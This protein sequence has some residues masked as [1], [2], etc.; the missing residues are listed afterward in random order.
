MSTWAKVYQSMGGSFEP[1]LQTIMPLVF[2]SATIRAD[3]SVIGEIAFARR[4]GGLLG[5]RCY[6]EAEHA[7]SEREG[8]EVLE[9][10]GQ[11]VE[12][13]TA[14]LEEKC[15]AFDVLLVICSVMGQSFTPY[16]STA[17]QLA[18]PALKFFFHDGV[19]ETAAL[20]VYFRHD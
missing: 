9:M 14:S 3:V 7:A 16:L 18:L 5:S 8:Y 4:C 20:F 11:R 1:Y 10:Q 2:R 15:T 13:R 19:R 6:V 17:L 12:I